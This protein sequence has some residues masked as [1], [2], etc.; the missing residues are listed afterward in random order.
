MC[1]D[2]ERGTKIG[3]GSSQQAVG[4]PHNQSHAENDDDLDGY[5]K[6]VSEDGSEFSAAFDALFLLFRRQLRGLRAFF[7]LL[8]DVFAPVHPQV[9]A[10]ADRHD[11][12]KKD[13]EREQSI[14]ASE[15]MVLPLSDSATRPTDSPAL[16]RTETSFTGRIQPPGAGNSTV[17]TRVS[18]SAIPETS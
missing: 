4:S 15:S 3:A 1:G 16:M 7:N 14:S 9:E 2:G 8:T 12:S 13:R 17:S 5:A 6:Y 18:S 10:N 11:K